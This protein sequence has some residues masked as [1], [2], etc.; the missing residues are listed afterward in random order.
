MVSGY[1]GEGPG[2]PTA[3]LAC[4]K[5][6]AGYSETQGGRDAGEA[7]LT[8]RKLRSW[9]LPPFERAARAGCR[10]FMLGYQST[11]CTA[12]FLTWL[13]DH[14]ILLASL[15]QGDIDTWLSEWRDRRH[16]R[17]FLRWAHERRLTGN[18]EISDRPRDEPHCWWS[19]SEHWTH[20]RRCLHDE[21]LPLDVRVTGAPCCCTECRSHE[22]LFSRAPTSRAAARLTCA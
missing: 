22:S 13:G 1:Q 4:A 9:F 14:D 5:H 21:A 19:E 18:L 15:T 7:D 11:R 10:T 12:A 2:D 20:L 3:V 16:V 8:P 6:F 17:M